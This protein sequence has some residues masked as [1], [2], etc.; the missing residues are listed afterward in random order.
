MTTSQEINDFIASVLGNKKSQ[1]EQAAEINAA[2]QKANVSRDQIAQATG[3][4]L[5]TVKQFLGPNIIGQKSAATPYQIYDKASDTYSYTDAPGYE[6]FQ[7]GIP[8]T[9]TQRVAGSPVYYGPAMQQPMNPDL[10]AS[11]AAY[12]SYTQG[13]QTVF[14]APEVNTQLAANNEGPPIG[15]MGIYDEATHNKFLLDSYLASIGGEGGLQ[16]LQMNQFAKPMGPGAYMSEFDALLQ[17]PDYAPFIN[18]YL[19]QATTFRPGGENQFF[20]RAVIGPPEAR[21][22]LADFIRLRREQ[23]E[24]GGGG[25]G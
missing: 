3:Y 4:D 23:L 16:D 18:E 20:E 2:A 13:P 7:Q 12:Q 10:N 14:A 24:Q 9:P 22:S 1:Q 5:D 15:D 17:K 8:L 11:A 19:S 25:G 6:R 21:K